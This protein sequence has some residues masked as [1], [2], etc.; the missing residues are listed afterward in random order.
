MMVKTRMAT[1]FPRFEV[2]ASSDVAAKAV[3]LANVS[4]RFLNAPRIP[5]TKRDW[6]TYSLMP[7]PMPAIA[8][9]PLSRRQPEHTIPLSQVGLNN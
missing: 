1:Y 7:A 2:G 3:S 6:N 4:L 5:K 9:P 8:I